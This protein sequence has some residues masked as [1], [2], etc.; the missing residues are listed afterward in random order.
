M[1]SAESQSGSP[2][3]DFALPSR[4]R[5]RQRAGLVVGIVLGAYLLIAYGLLPL[6]WTR[7]AHRHPALDETPGLTTTGDDHPGDPINVVLIGTE[8][9]LKT[10]MQ[11][12]GW[13]AADP[14]GLK[15]D[16]RIAADTVLKK[17][18]DDA[19]V[20]NLY[21]FGRK[22]D[23][24]FEQPVGD[25]PRKRHH[26]RFWRCAKVDS[27]GRPAWAGSATYDVRV[28][29][30]HST[31]Q[32]THHIS[33]DVDAERGHLIDSLKQAGALTRTEAI[34]GFHKV[35]EG[36]NGGGDPWHTDGRLFVGVMVQ[37]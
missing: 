29:L 26:V 37:Q 4:K 32:I 15:S 21:L 18:Y 20:S 31:G 23:F 33:A 14:L 8:T 13:H 7:Y 27:E 36:R 28:G 22:E 1:N 35:L 30:S 2:E 5:W 17:S 25:D 12:A 6:A 34:D 24:A 11:A 9:E 3:S 10:G 16:L 19:P